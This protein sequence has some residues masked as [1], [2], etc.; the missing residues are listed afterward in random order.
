MNGIVFAYQSRVKTVSCLILSFAVSFAG[1]PAW[2]K[3]FMDFF[4]TRE[5][6]RRREI[7]IYS[8]WIAWPDKMFLPLLGLHAPFSIDL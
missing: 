5:K 6:Y 8:R 7:S 2:E 4:E 3:I 1:Q